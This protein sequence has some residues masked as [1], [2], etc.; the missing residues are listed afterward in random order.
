MI[1]GLLVW[2]AFGGVETL[3]TEH[4][5]T[6][7][8]HAPMPSDRMEIRVPIVLSWP[9]GAPKVEGE[10]GCDV[11][12]FVDEAGDI[13]HTLV[14]GCTGAFVQGAS[15]AAQ[16]MAYEPVMVGEEARKVV[17]EV[18]VTFSYEVLHERLSRGSGR[19]VAELPVHPKTQ[20][21]V[22]LAER[23]QLEMYSERPLP[24]G[25]TATG[26]FD[27]AGW[28]DAVVVDPGCTDPKGAEKAAKKWR[29]KALE[30]EGQ[31]IAVAL[32]IG[33]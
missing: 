3:P 15:K 10:V 14:S 6:G 19:P 18:R 24:E 17:T 26:F 12:Q 1:W 13:D 30:D 9:D 16:A 25:C 33:G 28:F 31:P 4:P 5:V 27:R 21:R 8:A 20:E 2:A 32:K 23:S 29:V 7:E 22:E 11:V